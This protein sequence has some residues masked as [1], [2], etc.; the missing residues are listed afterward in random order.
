MGSQSA[1]SCPSLA[2]FLSFCRWTL[3][4]GSF[5]FAWRDPPCTAQ[6][7]SASAKPASCRCIA[8][9]HRCDLE[10][11]LATV[12]QTS[13]VSVAIKVTTYVVFTISAVRWH[14]DIWA[15]AARV[16]D[17]AGIRW[18]YKNF[19]GVLPQP[20]PPSSRYLPASVMN[21]SYRSSCGTRP[22][23]VTWSVRTGTGITR[24][25]AAFRLRRA[26]RPPPSGIAQVHPW[27]PQVRWRQQRL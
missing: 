20:R 17:V 23:P 9:C 7:P 15:I 21:C 26:S 24:S 11:S 10:A 3:I 18:S 13:R 27:P 25:P 22:L 4:T 2:A 16:Q 14:R 1:V 8:Q 19:H 5:G 6:A 12:W